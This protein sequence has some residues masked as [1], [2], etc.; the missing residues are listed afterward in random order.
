MA[1]LLAQLE[2]LMDRLP[3]GPRQVLW[4]VLLWLF[5]VG[6]VTVVAF[7]IRTMIP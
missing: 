5:G 7:A 1:A 6:C 4:F 2:G 3:P